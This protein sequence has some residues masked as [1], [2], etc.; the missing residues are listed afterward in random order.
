MAEE[1]NASDY[2]GDLREVLNN[3]VHYRMPFGMF[4]PEK[5]PPKGVLLVDLPLE[6]L[7]WFHQ[8]SFPKG[9]LG[10]MMMQV[11]ELKAVGMDELFT[12]IRKMHGGRTTLDPKKIKR[13]QLKKE[14]SNWGRG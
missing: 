2:T 5:Y 7:S 13:E 3:L 1:I 9:Q 11:Y 6:Y 10:E 8:R 14:I 4:G 12:P